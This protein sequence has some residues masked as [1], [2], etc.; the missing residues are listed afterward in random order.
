[1]NLSG[2]PLSGR[3]LH[4]VAYYL[5]NNGSSVTAVDISFTELKD[6][7]LRLLLPFLGVLPKLTTLAINGNRL[8][9]AILKDLIEVVKDPKMFPSLAWVD[10]GNNVGH[11]YCAS[12][13]AGRL[14]QTLWNEKQSTYHLRIQWGSRQQLLPRDFY[15]G[16]LC[17][18]RGRGG[19]RGWA[20]RPSGAGALEC[21]REKYI[22][23]LW[24]VM[25]LLFLVVWY[26][27]FVILALEIKVQC[28]NIIKALSTPLP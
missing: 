17:V 28:I 8:T 11:L 23:L 16:N 12:A 18:W 25:T 19:G 13:I 14:T 10:L 1:M 20:G 24:K 4:R 5:Q 26:C 27:S 15:W 6:D 9:V 2:I 3:D 7:S 22:A 21:R